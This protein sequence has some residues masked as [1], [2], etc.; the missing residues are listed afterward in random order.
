M[1]YPS[2]GEPPQYVL[3]TIC[4]INATQFNQQ[5]RVTFGDNGFFPGNH[6]WYSEPAHP[7]VEAMLTT[8]SDCD[9]VLVYV[10]KGYKVTVNLTISYYPCSGACRQPRYTINPIRFPVSEEPPRCST[11]LPSATEAVTMNNDT[12]SA[13]EVV[14][15]ATEIATTNNDT[16]SATRANQPLSVVIQAFAILPAMAWYVL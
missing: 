2:N 11:V 3:F 6:S 12:T 9:E 10:E 15:L 16:T 13:T 7:Y 5:I 8:R 14:S 4:N 1:I